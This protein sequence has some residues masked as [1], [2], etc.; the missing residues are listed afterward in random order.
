MIKYDDL[1]EDD[2]IEN[3]KGE[4]IE[5]IKHLDNSPTS[6]ESKHD[7]NNLNNSSM[8][9]KKRKRS[10]NKNKN[11]TQN[12]NFR[13]HNICSVKETLNQLNTGNIITQEIVSENKSSPFKLFIAK[14]KEVK[15]KT[16]ERL[17]QKGRN[18]IKQKNESY[19]DPESS[20]EQNALGT[21]EISTAPS[22]GFWHQRY[23]YFSKFDEGIKLDY[24]SWYS[25]TPEEISIY[26]AKL[27]KDCKSSENLSSVVDAFCGSGG[28]TIQ[29]SNFCEKVYAIDIDEKKIELC[30]N[31]VRVYKCDDQKIEFINSDYLKINTSHS[32]LKSEC[33]FLSPPWGGMDYSKTEKYSLKKWVYPDINEILKTSLQISQNLILYLPRNTDIQELF[34]L[35]SDVISQNEIIYSKYS[36]DNQEID[37]TLYAEIQMLFSAGKVKAILVLFGKNFNQISVKDIRNYLNSL[38]LNIEEYQLCQLVH[39]VKV[40]GVSRFFLAE[41]NY[42]KSINT[43]D[44]NYNKEVEKIHVNK[45]I[46]NLIKSIKEEILSDE[47]LAEYQKL[48][49][50]NKSK[51][52]KLNDDANVEKILISSTSNKLINISEIQIEENF[53][54]LKK[55]KI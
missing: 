17:F 48:D 42:R 8:L 14:V 47:E 36:D 51:E 2:S 50:K 40:I 21:S 9:S 4:I 20:T 37:T 31:N 33:V 24:E 10:K 3:E 13:S 12:S 53:E 49:K 16:D 6:K 28:N 39:L 19:L 55:Q 45:I 34:S 30:K 35:I 46:S 7:I 26:I 44:G 5:K 29:F 18:Y 38:Y 23:Y 15:F 22:E 11:S 1:L 41:F 52:K 54:K 25:V 43:Q 27:C 32:N